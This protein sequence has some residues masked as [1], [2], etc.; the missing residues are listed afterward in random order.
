MII[1]YIQNEAWTKATQYTRYNMMMHLYQQKQSVW[2]EHSWVVWLINA[3]YTSIIIISIMSTFTLIYIVYSSKIINNEVFFTTCCTNDVCPVCMTV[4]DR[5]RLVCRG[6]AV[7]SRGPSSAMNGGASIRSSCTTSPCSPRPV[8]SPGPTWSGQPW[9]PKAS[10]HSWTVSSKQQ[11]TVLY[12]TSQALQV[13]SPGGRDQGA[14]MWPS[15]QRA[16]AW[17]HKNN[18]V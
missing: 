14:L 2:S 15:E 5:E 12:R 7:T 10:S 17:R 18:K 4:Y 13:L 3:T 9:S 16:T 1:Y 8:A 6:S 11:R